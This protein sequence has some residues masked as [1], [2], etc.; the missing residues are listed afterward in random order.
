ML[1][2]SKYFELF[3]FIN[4]LVIQRGQVIITKSINT[5]ISRFFTY[6]FFSL[7]LKWF[8]PEFAILLDQ[9][10]QQD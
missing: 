10:S 1:L 6:N 3:Q 9:T 8:F 2:K 4:A 7:K 5:K